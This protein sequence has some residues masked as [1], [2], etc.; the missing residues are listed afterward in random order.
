MAKLTLSIILIFYL[1]SAKAQSCEEVMRYVKSSGYG[2]TFSSY[3]SDAISKVTFYTLTIDYENY[4]YAI[5]CFKKEYYGCTEYIY[6][7]NSA[8]K[9]GYSM[10]YISSAGKAF[11]DYI[12]PYG[13][14]L[15]CA[16]RFE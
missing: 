12:Q 9:L 14:V 15:G 4:Y 3:T 8:T 11:W 2:S 5:V 10:N 1:L 6:Q 16:P 7:V 13:K